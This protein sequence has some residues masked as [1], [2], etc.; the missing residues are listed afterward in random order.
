L[1]YLWDEDANIQEPKNKTVEER[2]VNE[3]PA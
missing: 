1:I 3:I 2:E